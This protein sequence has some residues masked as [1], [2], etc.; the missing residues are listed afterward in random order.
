MTEAGTTD[1]MSRYAPL[2]KR[3][4]SVPMPMNGQ[5]K[6]GGDH[7][8]E[9]LDFRRSENALGT[10]ARVDMAGQHRQRGDYFRDRVLKPAKIR[11]AGAE[12]PFIVVK[13]DKF[14]RF[15]PEGNLYK[16]PF[17]YCLTSYSVPNSKLTRGVSANT[18]HH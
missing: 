14:D 15:I 6:H 1:D 10:I 13:A 2:N 7:A 18:F 9:A 3:P 5:G 17:A 12:L 4:W 8:L 16:L 11:D